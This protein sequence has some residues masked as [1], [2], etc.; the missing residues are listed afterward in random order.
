MKLLGR[1]EKEESR[2]RALSLLES[3]AD[4][5]HRWVARCVGPRPDLDDIAQEALIEVAAALDAF[6][7]RSSIETYCRR[8]VMRVAIRERRRRTRVHDVELHEVASESDPERMT[9]RKE[10]IDAVYRALD[11]LS[12]SLREAIVLCDIE[13]LSH[14]EAAEVLKT[15]RVALRARL[16]RGRQQLRELLSYPEPDTARS[17]S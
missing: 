10:T 17:D 8:I 5:V 12:D 11:Q 2:A 6:E 13:G 9:A 4:D 16:K 3:L 1:Q 7:G 15:N 14:D